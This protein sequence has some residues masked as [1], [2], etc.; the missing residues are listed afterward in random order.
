MLR[1]QL[2]KL[3]S[4]DDLTGLGNRRQFEQHRAQLEPGDAVLLIDIDHFKRVND[5]FGHAAGDVTL[6]VVAAR[7]RGV[8]R[9]AGRSGLL[10]ARCVSGAGSASILRRRGGG[11]HLPS[12]IA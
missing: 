9:L 4:T 2:E 1:G 7:V 8:L 12:D 5:T 6:Q 3:S 11:R 10:P